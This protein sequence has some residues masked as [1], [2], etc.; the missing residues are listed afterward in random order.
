MAKAIQIIPTGMDAHIH[1]NSH[2]RFTMIAVIAYT[3]AAWTLLVLLRSRFS[4]TM[5]FEV[6]NTSFWLG[7][8]GGF[9]YIGSLRLIGMAFHALF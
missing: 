6:L 7:W 1:P 4:K 5:T 2:R 3:A 9:I 8:I